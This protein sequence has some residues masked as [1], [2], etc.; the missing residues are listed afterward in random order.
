MMRSLTRQQDEIKSLLTANADLVKKQ[1][2]SR[3]RKQLLGKKSK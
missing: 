1:P 2:T 3:E